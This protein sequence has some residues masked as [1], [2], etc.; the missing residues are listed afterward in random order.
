MSHVFTVRVWQED[1]DEGQAEW[2]GRVQD[3]TTGEMAYFRDLSGLAV[4]LK[5]L[6]PPEPDGQVDALG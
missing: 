3:C 4:V 2:R 1:L 5:R 6:L